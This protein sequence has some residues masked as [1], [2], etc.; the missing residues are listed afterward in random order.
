[1]PQGAL[2]RVVAGL[3]EV[4]VDLLDPGLV[5]DRGEGVWLLQE[6]SVGSAPWLPWTWYSHSAF[7][8][9]GSNSS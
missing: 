1:M 3:R 4:A 2:K 7:V 5:A 9:Q 6:P 8:Y